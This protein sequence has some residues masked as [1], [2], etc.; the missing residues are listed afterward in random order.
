MAS[1]PASDFDSVVAKI[2]TMQ[3]RPEVALSEAPAPRR[4]APDALALTAEVVFDDADLGNGR[5]VVLH[6]PAGEEAW[7]GATRLVVYI[8][9][10][11]EPELAADPL[12]PQ[13]GWS[14]LEESLA[15]AEATYWALGGTITRVQSESFG[16]M[17]DRGS[18]GRVQMRASWTADVS[19]LPRHVQ[20]W[21]DLL[22][23]ACGLEPL[24]VG[25]APLRSVR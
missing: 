12:L 22:A 5:L 4:M 14:W 21:A 9:A 6:N 17:A 19:D 8:D 13:V 10:L 2:R 23:T 3:L 15:G 20:A 11:V 25:V 7:E 1:L 18:E 24:P 16:A